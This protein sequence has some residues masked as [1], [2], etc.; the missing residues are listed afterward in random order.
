MTKN[1][2]CCA[3][4]LKNHTSYDCHLWYTFVIS[5]GVFLN[6]LKIFIFGVVSGVEGHKMVQ[7]D[8]NILSVALHVSETIHDMIV[9]YGTLV[10][11]NNISRCFFH[12]FKILILQIVSGLKG[13]EMAQNDKKFCLSHSVSQEPYIIFVTHV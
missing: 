2:V 3:P 8:K 6:F 5:P 11:T 9:I 10:E 7:N 13:Q 1:T 12:F 4:Y